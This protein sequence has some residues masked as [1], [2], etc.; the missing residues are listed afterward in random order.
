MSLSASAH[1]TRFLG[2]EADI[3]FGN[4]SLSKNN[5]EHKLSLSTGI[6]L[7]DDSTLS[8]SA[9]ALFPETGSEQD[10]F[11]EYSIRF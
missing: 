7:T 3:Q 6:A 11:A 10:V 1:S 9:D 5:W 4:V 8:I 2:G